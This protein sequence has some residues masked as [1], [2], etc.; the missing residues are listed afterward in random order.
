[1]PCV[2]P[3]VLYEDNH[4]LVIDK[5]AGLLSQGDAS[6]SDSALDWGKRYIA[7]RYNK[8]GAVFLGLVHRLDRPVSGVM[9]L[10]RTSKAAARLSEAFR[11]RQTEKTYRALVAPPPRRE[12]DTLRH[13]LVPASEGVPTRIVE[14]E[15]AGS[16]SAV[17]HYQTLRPHRLGTELEIRLETGR[18][19]QIRA[20]LSHM[21]SPILGDH[22]YGS[23]TPYIPDRIALHAFRITFPHPIGGTETTLVSVP[24]WGQGSPE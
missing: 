18:K 2:E 15:T 10:A 12:V 22:R 19:H 4:L 7:T 13:L 16:Q 21:G 3:K 11:S 6:Q 9:V 17:L 20:Q 8:P 23:R 14:E 24:P 1:M 5:P